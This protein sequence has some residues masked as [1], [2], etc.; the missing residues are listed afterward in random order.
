MLKILSLSSLSLFLLHPIWY[1]SKFWT[2]FLIRWMFMLI[3]KHYKHYPTWTKQRL[4]TNISFTNLL[5]LLSLL[6][7]LAKENSSSFNFL[8]IQNISINNLLLV[9]NMQAI[10]NRCKHLFYSGIIT[11]NIIIVPLHP[12]PLPLHCFLPLLQISS[13][14]VHLQNRISPE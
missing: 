6:H 11:I 13:C 2:L 12:T 14:V 9:K 8:N 7:P 10:T 3:A 1:N 5:L 4:C